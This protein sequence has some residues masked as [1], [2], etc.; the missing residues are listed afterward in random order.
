MPSGC[1]IKIILI[2]FLVHTFILLHIMNDNMLRLVAMSKHNQELVNRLKQKPEVAGIIVQG[3]FSNNP[4]HE[5]DALS[6]LDMTVVIDSGYSE[7]IAKSSDPRVYLPWLNF[8][9]YQAVN[10]G[11]PLEV[12]LY[13]FDM[14]ND[15]RP[16]DNPAREAFAYS[17]TVVYDRTGKVQAWLDK[18]T[19]LTPKLR[20]YTIAKLLAQAETLFSHVHFTQDQIDK[21]ILLTKVVK[22]LVEVIFYI[23]WEYPPDTKWRVSGSQLLNWKPRE[24]VT[25]LGCC[26]NTTSLEFMA[27]SIEKLLF[28]VKAKLLE[29]AITLKGEYN[30]ECEAAQLDNTHLIARL[31]T[32]LDKYSS[33]SVKK[34]IRRSLPW[35]A[36]D[37]V[38]EGVANAVD[39]I[40][41]INGVTIPK[42][43]KVLGLK[44]LPWL[45]KNCSRYLYQASSVYN[46]QDADDAANRSEAL[47]SLFISI[48]EKIEKM[49]IFSTSSLYTE[50]FMGEDLF[51][52]T[53]PYMMVFK[54]GMYK[55]RQQEKD[56]FAEIICENI[57]LPVR[58][59]NILWGMC[60]HYLIAN[61]SE[62]LALDPKSIH[63]Y[64]LPVWKKVVSE[65]TK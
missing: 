49:G 56:T 30:T 24:F 19:E 61:E 44:D 64:Y 40:Y 35:N 52:K 50:D 34:C 51:S 18:N 6:D 45:P 25:T 27:Q 7:E 17:A 41:A 12:D 60:S 62:L 26:N 15:L 5:T 58:E 10:G 39:I 1:C 29:E 55:N 42:Y 57:N 2:L 8:K 63:P 48:K 14:A 9:S 47:R 22:L 20:N 37:L 11:N 13:Y 23:N 54:G 32:R 46:Y 53:S 31:F 4:R 3:S 16:W 59:K 65:L 38:S 21:R 33:H 36:H 43:D 28:I